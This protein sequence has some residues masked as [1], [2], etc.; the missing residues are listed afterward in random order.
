MKKFYTLLAA[1]VITASTFAQAPEKMS[2][3][4]VVRDSGANLVTSQVVGMRISILQ[5]TSTGTAVYVETHAETTNANGLLTLQVG[6]GSVQSGTF[7]NIDWS[8]GPYFVKT[9]TDPAGST[10]YTITGTQQ[11]MSVPYALYAETSGAGGGSTALEDA[12]LDTKI[13]V[14]ETADEDI[15][16]F[17]IEGTERWVMQ[18]ARLEPT[19][20]GNSLFIGQGAGANDDLTDNYNVFVGNSAGYSNT[21][22]YENTANGGSALR[23]NT[24][25]FRNTANG[26]SALYS[27]TT[28]SYN[29]A[30]GS[31][32]LYF[33]TEGQENTANGYTALHSNT[34]GSYNT[35]NGKDA[36][37]F[38]TTGSYNTANG[39]NALHS[40][41][42]GVSN[43]ANGVY[44]LAS[45]TTGDNNTANGG[46]A[47][48]FNTTG[49]W[50]TTN[51]YHSL[52]YNTIGSKNTANGGSALYSNTTGYDNTANG[53]QALYPNTTGYRNTA[54]GSKALF[55]NTTGNDNTANGYQ[56]LYSNTTGIFNTAN[57]SYALYSNT[58]GFRNTALGFYAFSTGT[59]YVNSTALGYNAYIGASN[60]IRLGDASVSS[61]G[62]DVNWTNLSDGRF[63]T[64]VTENVSGLD[65]VMQLR[66][67]TYN[68]DM[69]AIAK[70]NN[71]P[72]SLRLA[73][74]EALKAAELQS[75][76]IAQEVEAAA[77]A[78]GYDFHGVDKPKNETSH[79]G[80][81]Y[82]E[83][84]VPMV[85]AMQEQQEMIEGQNQMI[86]ELRIQNEQLRTDLQQQ[87]NELKSKER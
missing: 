12:D 45:N 56:A 38:N 81:R 63:K 54:N 27:N 83:F 78:V 25:G 79:Y 23:F 62:G 18:G 39:I 43:T 58:T 28:G 82:A 2:Y 4:A 52:H 16:R 57:G 80:L 33:N 49:S 3:Q 87:I 72:D 19:N 60:T 29:T 1:L 14:E 41:T 40:N 61:I 76:F 73:E 69:D 68:L 48:Y 77:T 67:V 34:T 5:T 24:T 50:N 15:I 31:Y 36:L 7:A 37:Y 59:A 8:A 6:A 30:N 75:G 17:D 55:S 84:V 74:S 26:G 51:G 47:L 11:M 65:F 35:A 20:T 86:E 21:T 53:Y 71:T 44:A 85:K 46:A 64:N 10:A 22:G 13:Q 42:T 9:E 66:P 32:A 70:F